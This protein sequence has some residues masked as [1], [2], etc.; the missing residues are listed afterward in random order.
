MCVCEFEKERERDVYIYICIYVCEGGM[1]GGGH[2]ICDTMFH[3]L[4]Y[5]CK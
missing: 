1:G 3:N 2:I 5:I 4:T